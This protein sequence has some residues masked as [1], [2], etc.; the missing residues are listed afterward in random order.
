MPQPMI[1]LD[2]EVRH[3]A[4]RFH[5]QF[6]QPQEQSFVTVRPGLM[7]CEGRRTRSGLRSNVG[8]PPRLSGLSRLFSDAPWYCEQVVSR[9][10][11]HVRTEMHPQVEAEWERQ[12]DPQ[13]KRRGRPKE[14]LVTGEDATM[15]QPNGRK[16]EGLGTPHWTT[17]DQRIVGHR[18][19]QGLSVRVDRTC[20]LAA[21]RYRQAKICEAEEVPFS[22]TI[23]LRETQ[24]RD[25]EPVAGRQTPILLDRC[26]C[27]TCV[28]HPAGERDVLLT[29]GLKAVRP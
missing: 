1:G 29:T 7:E 6:S 26:S 17:P 22:C 14:P 4:E 3:V 20:P 21:H 15:S 27:A 16:R 5:P 9:W 24:I 13:P 10:Q 19:V 12:R 2:K 18:L 25:G 28:W 11:R 8:P 23:E